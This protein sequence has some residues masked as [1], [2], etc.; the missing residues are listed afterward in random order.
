MTACTF[1]DQQAVFAGKVVNNTGSS[2]I[3]GQ[4]TA[5]VRQKSSG[6]IVATGTFLLD[7]TDPAAPG[8]E[9]NYYFAVPLPENLDPATLETE[10]TAKGQQP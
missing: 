8:Q 4:V 7:I 2:L 10:V 6:E 5:V 1:D 3:N 9:L